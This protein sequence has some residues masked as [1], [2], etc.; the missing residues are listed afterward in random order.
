MPRTFSS[1][2][3]EMG[4]FLLHLVNV[5]GINGV[6][7]VLTQGTA[8]LPVLKYWDQAEREAPLQYPIMILSGLFGKNQSHKPVS[9]TRS[10]ES[11]KFTGHWRLFRLVTLL[12][13]LTARSLLENEHNPF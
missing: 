7:G 3:G 1:P 13:N 8:M 6:R 5:N 10:R 12:R 11:E 9:L 2:E 4:Y